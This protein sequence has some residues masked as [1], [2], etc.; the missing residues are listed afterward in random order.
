MTTFYDPECSEFSTSLPEEENRHA[1]KSL[2]LRTGEK[3]NVVNGKGLK[4]QCEVEFI[5]KRDLTFNILNVSTVERRRPAFHLA[6]SPLKQA[7]RFEYIIEKATEL[8]VDS[9]IPLLCS[10]T[11]K[12]HI[13]EDRLDR[14]VISALK[15]SGNPYKPEIHQVT[16]IQDFIEGSYEGNVLI[17]HCEEGEKLKLNEVDHSKDIV[18]LI[19]PEG[20]FTPEEIDSASKAGFQAIDLGE[21]TLR[22]ETAAIG[23]TS[24]FQ[25][26]K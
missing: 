4:L 18:F 20:D 21:L 9:I 5:D 1:I 22:A 19:G 10:R 26:L 25:L 11:E 3:F 8:G 13:K 14:I 23:V 15:Q 24:Y 12:P 7:D 2:R 16:K 17:A 6:V